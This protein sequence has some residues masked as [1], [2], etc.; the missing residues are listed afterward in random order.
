MRYLSPRLRA[1]LRA[2]A[3]RRLPVLILSGKFGLLAPEE[4]IPWYDAPLTPE[5]ARAL[6]PAVAAQLRRLRAARLELHATPRDMPGWA[7]YYDLLE[8]ACRAAGV[9]LSFVVVSSR[10]SSSAPV[11]ESGRASANARDA[12]RALHSSQAR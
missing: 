11:K 1:V 8:T 4:P 6:V 10:D 9:E 5:G 3:R 12:A 7:P 2:G